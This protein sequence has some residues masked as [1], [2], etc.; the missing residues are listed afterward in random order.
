MLSVKIEPL[1]EHN[2][3]HQDIADQFGVSR[4]RITQIAN[5]LGYG[6]KRPKRSLTES[7]W[8]SLLAEQHRYTVS[9]LSRKYN[10]SRAAIY[11]RRK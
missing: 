9:E 7:Q 8:A 10:I 1:L 3:S 5:N 11:K 6:V 4:A 2:W